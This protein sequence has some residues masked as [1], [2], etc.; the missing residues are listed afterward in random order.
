MVMAWGKDMAFGYKLKIFSLALLASLVCFGQAGRHATGQDD[1]NSMSRGIG[2]NGGS[3]QGFRGRGAAGEQGQQQ[4][5]QVQ[6]AAGGGGGGGGGGA[7]V[8]ESPN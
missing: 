4:Q 2:N 8:P 7:S 1:S 5:Q 3:L 6:G